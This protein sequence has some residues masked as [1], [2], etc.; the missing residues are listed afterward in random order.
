MFWSRVI[1]SAHEDIVVKCHAASLGSVLCLVF[2]VSFWVRHVKITAR[3]HVNVTT[4]TSLHFT[5]SVPGKQK[6]S[7]IADEHSL[8]SWLPLRCII[9][10]PGCHQRRRDQ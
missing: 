5:L 1:L 6:S 7:R 4:W 10:G 3:H 8:P 2:R 9:L